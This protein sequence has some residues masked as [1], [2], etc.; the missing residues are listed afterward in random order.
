MSVQWNNY[1]VEIQIIDRIIGGI[2]IV[3]AGADRADAYEAWAR[4][5][6]VEDDP[7]FEQ[8]LV[9]ALAEDDDMPVTVEDVEGLETGFRSSPELG[10][11]IECRQVKA[12]LRESAQRLGIIKKVRGSRQVLQHDLLVRAPDGTQ[13][14]PLGLQ[15]PSGKDTRPIS[16]VTRQGPRTAIRRFDY[17][18]QPTLTFRV[19]IL[20]GGVGDGLL[21]EEK[22]RD[23]L[24]FGGTLGLGA[25]RSQGE[26]C[27]E[28]LSL[29]K[30]E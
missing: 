28:L 7:S 3:P 22:L 20:A 25:D 12:M 11:Y 30:A 23:M 2:P 27:F 19:S 14:L 13:K 17:C 5:Q 15:E 6:G 4:G 29:T 26:G 1:D 8:P 16:V 21:D 24:E 10:L 18:V 9:E